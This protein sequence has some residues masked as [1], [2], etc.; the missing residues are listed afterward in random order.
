M[1][2][3]TIPSFMFTKEKWLADGTFD[4]VKARL[5]ASGDKMD[6][7]LYGDTSSP[8]AALSSILMLSA[9]AARES[10]HVVTADISGAYLNADMNEKQEPVFVVLERKVAAIMCEMLPEYSNF[11]NSRGCVVVE[12]KK[13]LYGCVQSAK[14][15]YEKLK[16]V[17][18]KMGFTVN[19][20]DG[21]IFNKTVDL[22]QIS[23][24]VYVDDLFIT[25]RSEL[26][27]ENFKKDL[28]EEFEEI[29]FNFGKKHNYLSMSFDFSKN[30][31]VKVLMKNY[32]DELLEFCEVEG[33]AKSPALETLFEI[34]KESEMLEV[35]RKE[36]F[37]S[38]VA[39]LLFLAKRVR[40]DVLLPVNFLATRVLVAT[41]S[42][43][44]KL[45]RV[46]KYLNGSKELGIVLKMG[47]EMGVIGSIDASYGVHSDGKSHSGMV[48]SV[49]EGPIFVKSSK[50]KIVT[51]SSYEAELVALSD[52]ASQVLWSREFLIG[53]G[54]VFPPTTIFQD[55][56][57]TIGSILKGGPSSERS[58][59]IS[60]RRFW[61]TERIEN[62]ELAIVYC[63]TD[64]M[65]SDLLTKP[66]Q[67]EKFVY[68]RNKLLNWFA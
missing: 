63:G 23:I 46:L 10:R 41:E 57:A 56:K 11:V 30:G 9:I 53:Q 31:E 33:T 28:L 65:V 19:P 45:E 20:V 32:V 12:L 59:H 5:V 35:S 42:D 68:L 13:A 24:G 43:W 50:Q 17:L 64:E 15:W 34:E 4:K 1:K 2:G 27:I 40:P 21:C 67:G 29:K 62:G 55:N 44:K 48:V 3:N 22:D 6:R 36:F 39:K 14:L 52:N 38:V 18:L 60:I 25:S 58:R 61:L 66:L 7:S 16:S 26:L 8:T 51:K 37:H 54:F 49:G 47:A